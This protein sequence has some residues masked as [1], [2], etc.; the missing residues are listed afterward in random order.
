MGFTSR[1]KST[2]M[3]AGGGR[4]ADCWP[5]AACEGMK[6]NSIAQPNFV[7]GLDYQPFTAK[8]QS[9]QS[10]LAFFVSLARSYQPSA[11]SCQL[12]ASGKDTLRPQGAPALV[13]NATRLITVNGAFHAGVLCAGQ[14]TRRKE[15]P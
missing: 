7:I 10:V 8:T 3:L 15:S 6:I 14:K 4:P 2:L 13:V 11:V 1:V 5:V 9:N 12:K